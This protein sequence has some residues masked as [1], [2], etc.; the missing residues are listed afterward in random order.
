MK[1]KEVLKYVKLTFTEDE[2]R[3]MME[4]TG[5]MSIQDFL[6]KEYLSDGEGNTYT[7]DEALALARKRHAAGELKEPFSLPEIYGD[8][9]DLQRGFSGVAGKRWFNFINEGNVADIEYVT[10]RR[11]DRKAVYRFKEDKDEK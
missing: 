7:V 11:S 1:S 5:G 3:R 10:I 2:Y 6:R 9:W 8:S 4:V